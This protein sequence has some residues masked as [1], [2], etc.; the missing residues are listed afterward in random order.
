MKPET[1]RLIAR[2]EESPD[3]EAWTALLDRL[4]ERYPDP[5]R[6]SDDVAHGRALREKVAHERVSNL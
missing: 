2:I 3:A 5:G 1:L 6:L 4:V